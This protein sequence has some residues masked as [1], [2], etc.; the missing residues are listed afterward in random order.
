MLHAEM[1]ERVAGLAVFALLENIPVQERR[2]GRRVHP[3]SPEVFPIEHGAPRPHALRSQEAQGLERSLEA[4]P[5]AAAA[6][7]G[8]AAAEEAL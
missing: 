7:W 5:G 1:D 4:P 2:E 6:R 3:K 8:E